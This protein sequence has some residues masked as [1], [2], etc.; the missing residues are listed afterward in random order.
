MAAATLFLEGKLPEI[1]ADAHSLAI[2]TYALAKVGSSRANEA[3]NMLKALVHENP[4]RWFCIYFFLGGGEGGFSP[5]F[6]FGFFLIL[7]LWIFYRNAI[8]FLGVQI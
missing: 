4:G 2:V 6:R 7:V 3:N 1:V 5:F 8:V